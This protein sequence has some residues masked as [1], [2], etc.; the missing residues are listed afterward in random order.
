MN[1][2]QK[3]ELIDK[4][5]KTPKEVRSEIEDMISS[6]Q[7]DG[8]ILS[9]IYSDDLFVYMLFFQIVSMNP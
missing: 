6:N 8:F 9:Y 2:S 1:T 4:S 5:E 3:L 7:L